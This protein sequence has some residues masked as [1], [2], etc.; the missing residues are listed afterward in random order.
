MPASPTC[1]PRRSSS[2]SGPRP[3]GAPIH[4]ML[5]R[6]V[7]DSASGSSRPARETRAMPYEQA[8]D[9]LRRPVRR[10]RR[11]EPD[12]GLSPCRGRAPRRRARLHP[13]HRARAGP[14]HRGRPGVRRRGGRHARRRPASDQAVPDRPLPRTAIATA[15]RCSPIP[16]LVPTRP[17]RPASIPA[18]S[19]PARKSMKIHEYQGKELLR[20]F[21][22]PVPR[23]YPAFSVL[24]G[25][26][27]GAEARR[28]GLGRQGADPCRRARQG[29]R[30][31]AGAHRSTR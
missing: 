30:R 5:L 9:G 25:R 21:G 20:Q 8:C 14:A 6:L 10:A 27:G 28:L 16:A 15:R 4:D 12:E 29:R 22:V 7:V 13:H 2:P 3:A 19:E 11:P 18:E 24:R 31:Q 1:A 26:R 17:R 23:G